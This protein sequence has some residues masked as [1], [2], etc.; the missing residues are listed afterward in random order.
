M[1]LNLAALLLTADSLFSCHVHF[2]KEY[3]TIV[4]A[5]KANNCASPQLLMVLFAVRKAENGRPGLEF[6]VLHPRAVDQPNSLR[7]QAG[8]CAATISKTYARWI[9]ADSPKDFI[10]Y[11]GA[12]YCPIDDPK[13]TNGLNRHWVKN[14]KHWVQRLA[15]GVDWIDAPASKAH[16]VTYR[17]YSPI[18]AARGH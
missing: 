4:E 2:G 10:S 9:D 14:V 11:L 12:R 1:P 18:T 17:I 6:G 5:A 13:D 16:A 15:G 3:T 7:V 8:W